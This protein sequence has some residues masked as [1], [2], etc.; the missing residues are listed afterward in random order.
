MIGREIGH[1]HVL[2]ELGSGGMGAVYLAQ[3]LRLGRR[4]ALKTLS[5]ALASQPRYVERF[6]R[7]AR[8]AAAL[9]H[10][11]IVTIYAVEEADGVPLISMEF[12]EG[13]TL[14]RLIP[15]G[16]F[17]LPRL[18]EIALPLCDAVAAAHQRGI[19]H[20]DLKPDNVMITRDGRVKVLDFGIAKPTQDLEETVIEAR[21][22][23]PAPV[24]TEPGKVLGTIPYMSP[25]QVQA[26]PVDSR[27]DLF[28]LGA[29]LYEM[30]T[31]RRPFQ[32]SGATLIGAILRDTPPP[33]RSLQHQ[34]PPRFDAIAARCLEKSLAGRYQTAAELRHDLA[35]LVGT[36][37]A[38]LAARWLT[39]SSPGTSILLPRT[40]TRRTRL[41][42]A[43]LIVL[44]IFSG[45]VGGVRLLARLKLRGGKDAAHVLPSLAVL[46]LDNLSKSPEYFVDG[47]TDALIASLGNVRGIRVIS[48][49]SV[50]R[51]KG[52]NKPLPEIA[53]ELGVDMVLE[54]TVLRSL[55]R[56]RI[57][58]HLIRASPEQEMW[59]ET[60]ERDLR[61]VLSLQDELARNIAS[62]IEV[63][64]TDQARQLFGRDRRVDPAALDAYLRGRFFWNRRGSEDLHKA[65]EYFDGAIRILPTYA[66]AWSGLADANTLL[67][68]QTSAPEEVSARARAAARRALDL[69]PLLAD[70][71]TSMGGIDLFYGWDWKA[72]ESEL[73]R[74]L[75][76]NSS[77][78][79]AH[80]WYWALL[81]TAGRQAEAEEQVQ[82][83]RS[84]DP[85]SVVIGNNY[86]LH[87][88]MRGQTASA[89]RQLDATIALDSHYAA[90]Y[91]NRWQANEVAGREAAAFA[92]YATM[93]RLMGYAEIAGEAE[94]V[95]AAAGHRPALAR[96]AAR[97]TAKARERFV[98]PLFIALTCVLA[99]DQERALDW[100]DKAY[101]ERAPGLV[102]I[103]A[104]PC[105]RA[106]DSQSRFLDLQ[107]RVGIPPPPAAQAAGR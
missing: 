63:E 55:E 91:S 49:Q 48:R 43:G 8:S 57:T 73:R 92:D 58:A 70:A 85:L 94:Q 39:A 90:G 87:L 14:A 29:I 31:G 13:E 22:V 97:L 62:T 104:N 83:A 61:D 54:G 95:Y 68:F 71:H 32:G 102:F 84:I 98:S 17:P 89:L 40:W 45:G 41:A 30:A 3:D 66:Q 12:L 96:S 79:T 26:L 21:D 74:A 6:Q 69:D 103:R 33:P 72:A 93:L 59:S 51:F 50:M 7:E 106:L 4:V 82:Q 107:R 35:G 27:T 34:L 53:R 38:S 64:L 77:D 25:E 18:L 42:A 76:L 80:I 88:L 15:E 9:S 2:A 67:G 37:Q 86:A 16:G 11:N 75:D 56:V 100:L 19:I 46:P 36:G 65:I 47:M 44:F 1:Y 24:L 99:G 52:S 78:A 23:R 5:P 105:Y 81:A 20:R 60:Y 10:P 101:T 28:S